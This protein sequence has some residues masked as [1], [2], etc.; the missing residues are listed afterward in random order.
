[1]LLNNN[2]CFLIDYSIQVSKEGFEMKNAVAPPLDIARGNSTSI[3]F[4][5]HSQDGEKMFKYDVPISQLYCF[6][7]FYSP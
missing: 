1:M 4:K 3:P 6:F 2:T 7:A 5:S